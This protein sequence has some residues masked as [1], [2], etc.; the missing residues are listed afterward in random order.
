MIEPSTELITTSATPNRPSS[1]SRRRM[2]IFVGSSGLALGV[3]LA[4]FALLLRP[5]GNDMIAMTVYLS[6]TACLSVVIGYAAF[7]L[8]WLNRSRRLLW[9]LM[10]GYLLAEALTFM[11]VL[12]TARLMFIS[13]H[14][15]LISAVLLL[16]AA[17]I[18]LSLGYLFS[19]AV[20]ATIRKLSDAAGRVAAGD[21]AVRVPEEGP[22]EL[23]E[24][25]RSFN[26]MTS[27]LGEAERRREELEGARRELITAVGHDLRTPLASMKVILEALADGVVE[28]PSTVDRY[29]K[30]AQRDLDTL[31]DLVDDLFMLAQ[32]DSGGLPLDRRPNS[33]SDLLSD[34]L[35]RFTPRAQ[36]QGVRLRGE[37]HVDRDDVVF[38][39]KYVARAL[40]NLVDNA[41]RHTPPGGEVLL[42][43]QG[44]EDGVVIQVKDSGTGIEAAD[45]PHL[46][47]R[48]YRAEPSRSRSTGGGGLGLAIV[49]GIVEAH[50]GRVAVESSPRRGATFSLTFPNLCRDGRETGAQI[51][52]SG[53]L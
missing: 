44:I 20:S 42:A 33:L 5:P 12:V 46:F 39:A 37:P 38:D 53:K 4:A 19:T 32:L 35:E 14:D 36:Q 30:T 22:G 50:G 29:L 34:T 8:G 43:T 41:L 31:S 52:S 48:F 23:A 27:R 10:A 1:P 9:T 7:R 47:E 17:L 49:K 40:A 21:L 3:G 18:A 15:V 11:N 45:L 28:D 51:A 24:L 2:A 26:R 6:L 13:H 25:S 16:F